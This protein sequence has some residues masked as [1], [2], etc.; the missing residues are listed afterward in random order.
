MQELQFEASWDKALSTQDRMTIE[1]IYYDTKHQ[2]NSKIVFSPIREASNHKQDLL[3]TALVHNFSSMP[4]SFQ[5]IRLRYCIKDEKVAEYIF[6][7]P[8]LTVPVQVSMPWTFIFPKGSYRNL[9]SIENGRLEV[10]EKI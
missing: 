3:V 10:S 6:H 2:N 9:N 5:N 7:L 4:F 1:K 8:K